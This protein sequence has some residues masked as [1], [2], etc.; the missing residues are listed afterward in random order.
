M[1]EGEIIKGGRWCRKEE[2]RG[3]EE[4]KKGR[5]KR[6]SGRAISSRCFIIVNTCSFFCTLIA[7]WQVSPLSAVRV[8]KH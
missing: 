1:W 7:S 5:G 6:K 3:G 4:K 2:E 8:V